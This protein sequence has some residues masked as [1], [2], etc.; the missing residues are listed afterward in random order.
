MIGLGARYSVEYP[1][2]VAQID[3]VLVSCRLDGYVASIKTVQFCGQVVFRPVWYAF[4]LRWCEVIYV[5]ENLSLPR[6]AVNLAC[7]H[8]SMRGVESPRRG[9]GVHVTRFLDRS[10]DSPQSRQGPVI[11]EQGR[12]SHVWVLGRARLPRVSLHVVPGIKSG[13]RFLHKFLN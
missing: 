3:S 1:K 10:V 8:F 6:F 12:C 7:G 2:T 4:T 5:L 9:L 13:T 11:I